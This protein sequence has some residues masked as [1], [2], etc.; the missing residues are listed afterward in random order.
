LFLRLQ[1]T[2]FFLQ[3]GFCPLKPFGF[4]TP[5]GA[6]SGKDLMRSKTASRFQK[7]LRLIAGGDLQMRFSKNLDCSASYHWQTRVSNRGSPFGEGFTFD[8]LLRRREP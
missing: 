7:K 6:L 1:L 3:L 5:A 4:A 8:Q 2:R